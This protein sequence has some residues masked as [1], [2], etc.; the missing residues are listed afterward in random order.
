MV[1]DVRHDRL[2]ELD[3]RSLNYPVTKHPR[4]ASAPRK[5]RSYTWGVDTW[6]DQGKE[7]ACFPA[8]TL[9]R[10]ADGTHRAIEQVSTLDRV[11]TAEGNEGTVVQTMVRKADGFVAIKLR[12]HMVVRC[13]PEHPV[14]TQRGYVPAAELTRDDRVAVTRWLPEGV[15]VVDT[16]VDTSGLRG[17]ISGQVNTGGVVSDIAPLPSL[18][19]MTPA[20]GRLMGLYAAEGCTTANKVV[21]SYGGHEEDTLVSETV[22]LIKTCFD[23][24]ARVQVRPNGAINVVLYGKTWRLL[25]EALVPGTSK[26]GD[27]HLSSFVASGG[28]EFL[29]SVLEGWLDG[30]GHRRRSQVEGV[31]V[32]KALALDMHAIAN[33]L[34]LAP[35]IS[36]AVP[37]MNRHAA[38][39]QDRYGVTIPLGDGHRQPM[40]DRAVWRKVVSVEPEPFEG[41][42]FNFHVEGDESYVADGLGVHNCVGFGFT[43]DLRAKPKVVNGV[44]ND[45]ARTKVYWEAQRIDEWEGGAYPGASPRYEGTSVLSGAKVLTSLGY[46]SGYTWALNIEQLVLGVGYAGGP[47]ILGLNWYEGMDDVDDDGF[48]HVTGEQDGGHCLLAIGVRIVWKAGSARATFADVDQ[49]RSY[50]L[51]HNSWGKDWAADGRAKISVA[52]MDRLLNEAGDA[53]FPVRTSKVLVG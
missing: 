42:V 40:D 45:F 3:W 37:S 6:L 36:R 30:D 13:T 24:V 18:L 28:S 5:P 38:T 1:E 23:A 17:V 50:F 19:A 34:G 12:G 21:W 9:V 41:W 7:G 20:M 4:M 15:D 44:T 26:H 8:G 11:V 46:Y 35:T 53:C 29:R 10:M 47:A 52:D 22:D 32:S 39:R 49:Q 2:Y 33:G 43:H 27:K 48:I 16:P 51:L 25:F 14:L 31:S